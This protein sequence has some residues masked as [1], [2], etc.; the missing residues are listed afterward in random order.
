MKSSDEMMN[1]IRER[2]D[3]YMAQRSKKRRRALTIALSV[4]AAGLLIALAVFGA[5]RLT[6]ANAPAPSGKPLAPYVDD[7]KERED[8]SSPSE[9]EKPL[10]GKEEPLDSNSSPGPVIPPVEEREIWGETT[11]VS[12]DALIRWEEQHDYVTLRLDAALKSGSDT[13]VFAV[14]ARPPIDPSFVFEGRTLGEY[15][16]DMGYERDLPEKLGQLQKEGDSLKYG[17]ALYETGTPEG[18][19]WA[20]SLYEERVAFYGS[21]VLSKYLVDGEFLKDDLVRDIAEAEKKTDAALAYERARAEYLDSLASSVK[22]ARFTFVSPKWGGFIVGLTREK[23][24]A[25]VSSHTQDDEWSFDLA[26]KTPDG[27]IAGEPGAV[28]STDDAIA[29]GVVE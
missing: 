12:P 8:P 18:E 29:F 17:P 24:T 3:R 6:S 13:D 21:E 1:S 26:E 19:K 23:F 28:V 20:R 11:D 16:S 14:F 7:M 2:R 9:G 4:L 25:F 22:G 15:A 5:M 27:V 10:P